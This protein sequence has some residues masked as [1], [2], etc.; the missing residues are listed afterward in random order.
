VLET[1][2]NGETLTVRFLAARTPVDRR[3]ALTLSAP[4]RGGRFL[5]FNGC[6]GRYPHRTAI[7]PVD[8]VPYLSERYASDFIRIDAEGRA[9][10]GDLTKN[11]SFFTYGEPVHA[12][13]GA[14]VVGTRNDVPENV[15]LYEP[16]GSAFTLQTIVGNR[17]VLALPGG[18]YATYGH[19]QTGSVR[20]HPGQR[21]R[22]GQ[23]LGLVGNTGQSGAAHLH[24][25][26]SDGPDPLAS[27]GVP[28]VFKRFTLAGAA[29]NVDRF[30]M[31]ANADVHPV[32][33]PARRHRELPMHAD[34]VRFGG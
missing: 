2:S 21:V 25:Q 20:V 28:Y 1:A 6:C 16:P 7:A 30:L 26:L 18:R 13:A 12:V 27:D 8:G 10:A 29:S 9:A 24:F 23:I 22:R 31:G 32:D 15:P 17:V 3:P 19:L 5:N 4:L 34:V 33:G 11:E 14:R